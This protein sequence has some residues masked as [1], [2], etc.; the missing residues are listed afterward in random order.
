MMAWRTT[1]ENILMAGLVAVAAVGC[2]WLAGSPAPAPR[3]RPGQLIVPHLDGT[4][5]QGTG[6]MGYDI[7]R[8]ASPNTYRTLPMWEYLSTVNR[9]F[10]AYRTLP[11][12]HPGLG[13]LHALPGPGISI[14][15][16]RHDQA[17]AVAQSSNDRGRLYRQILYLASPTA[18]SQRM[19]PSVA[20]A[21]RGLTP[22]VKANA[23]VKTYQ[24]HAGR[25]PGY[26]EYGP[27]HGGPGFRFL[28]DKAG[29]VAAVIQ[30]IPATI[31]WSR[32]DDQAHGHPV[33]WGSQLVYTDTLWF[34][35]PPDFPSRAVRP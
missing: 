17:T 29:R 2:S 9:S 10:G 13:V 26:T 24:A 32:W 20:P 21:I 33:K 3:P 35:V 31:G 23:S 6:P 27:A 19:G 34:N 5:Q 15:T 18:I 16:N 11:G 12:W 28:V 1:L 8:T 30:L 14:W 4:G 22:F 7:K 25:Y